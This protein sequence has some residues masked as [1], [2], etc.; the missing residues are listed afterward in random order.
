MTPQ[1]LHFR[2]FGAAVN[3]HSVAASFVAV[4]YYRRGRQLVERERSATEVG[5][6]RP[7]EAADGRTDGVDWTLEQLQ[8]AQVDGRSTDPGLGGRRRQW[9]QVVAGD[10]GGAGGQ[11][12]AGRADRLV[13]GQH[14][15][16]QDRLDQGEARAM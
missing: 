3:H 15:A 14:A 11:P 10:T 4:R 5:A 9:V 1:N 6:E 2:G 12:G 7:A 8:D 16:R 13:D